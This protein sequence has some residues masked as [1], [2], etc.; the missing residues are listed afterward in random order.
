MYK[1]V[2]SLGGDRGFMRFP[3]SSKLFAKL[4]ILGLGHPNLKV[5]TLTLKIK[6]FEK[7]KLISLLSSKMLT[8]IG[9]HKEG[10]VE[11]SQKE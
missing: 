8:F 5:S 11:A 10:L 2:E 4:G 6:F 9:S 3:T 7:L 1:K